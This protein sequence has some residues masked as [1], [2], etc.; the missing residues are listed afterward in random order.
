MA[1]ETLLL[2]G[3]RGRHRA[4]GV[5]GRFGVAAAMRCLG[6]LP[7]RLR[8][9]SEPFEVLLAVS[10]VVSGAPAAWGSSRPASLA[11]QLSPW[12]V[13]VW[14]V[15]LCLGGATTLWARWRIGRWEAGAGADGALAASLRLEMTGMVLLATGIGVYAAA[16]FAV[17]AAAFQAGSITA[18]WAGGF[19]LRAWI[20]SRTLAAHVP[21]PDRRGS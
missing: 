10:A 2:A 20:I 3:V 5:G 8:F 1:D 9:F 21:R 6:A 12:L 18:A 4:P 15:L 19:A 13:H 7:R 17:G 14:G 11:F 16:I